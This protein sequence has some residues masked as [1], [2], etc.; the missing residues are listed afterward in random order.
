[1]SEEAASNE[2]G[3]APGARRT[4]IGEVVSD[5]MQKTV[6]VRVERTVKHPLY[7]KYVRRSTKF[8]AHDED[9]DCRIGDT[10]A[11]EECRPL[12]KNKSWRVQRIVERAR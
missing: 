3:A 7:K 2:V 8:A 4:L 11:I 10:V 6:T 5:K 1:M 9:N 12:S